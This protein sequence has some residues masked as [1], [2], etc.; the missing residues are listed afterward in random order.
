MT[1]GRHIAIFTSDTH[2]CS[3]IESGNPSPPT[4]RC[5][6]APSKYPGFVALIE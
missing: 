1:A 5:P 4:R 2:W 3:S 6:Y